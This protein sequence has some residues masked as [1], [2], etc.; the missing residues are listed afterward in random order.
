MNEKPFIQYQGDSVLC[1]EVALSVYKKLEYLYNYSS[2]AQKGEQ[3]E[4]REPRGTLVVMDR[5]FDMLTPLTHTYEYQT[6]VFD[7]L[8]VPEDGSLDSVIPP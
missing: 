3:V 4:F 2:D 5:T 7:Y 8:D 6:C 1:E